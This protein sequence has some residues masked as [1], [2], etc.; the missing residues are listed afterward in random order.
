MK[1][2]RVLMLITEY[3]PIFSGHAIYLQAILPKFIEEGYDVEILT[4]DFQRLKAHEIINGI[5]VYRLSFDPQDP[6]WEAH[7]TVRILKFLFQ[8]RNKFDILHFHGHVDYYGALTMFCKCFHKKIIMQ[9]VLMGAD[10]PQSLRDRYKLMG[11]RLKILSQI[12]R[13]IHISRPLGES[14][15][16]A[17]FSASKL[18]YI[19]QGVDIGRF[20]PLPDADRRRLRE[21]LHLDVEGQIVSFVGAVIKRKGVDILIAAW[22][23]VQK[24]FPRAALVLIGPC[25]FG[26]DD[27]NSQSLLAFVRCIQAQIEEQNLNVTMTGRSSLVSSYL[28]VSD[29]FV[30]PSRKE[31]F[32]NVILEAMSCGIP[33]IVSYMDGVAL[34]SVIPNETGVIIQS[35]EELTT[36]I[37]DL[38]EDGNRR[39]VMGMR[40]RKEV[41]DRFSLDRIARQ[42]LAVYDELMDRK[43]IFKYSIPRH[44]RSLH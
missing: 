32:G 22:S 14:C 38:L 29:L 35:K 3:L 9:M 43:R 27:A 18:R 2:T 21:Q 17:G 23:E 11:L 30:L 26:T 15:L 34:E 31:G 40:A 1:R 8:H 41:L 7:L 39:K 33:P 19:P 42:Y 12:D 28:Q 4:C 13:F 24:V 16:H 20:Q 25:E 37:I 5:N 44:T 6:I 36:A 10:D